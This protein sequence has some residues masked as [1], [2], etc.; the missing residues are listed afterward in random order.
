[1]NQHFIPRFLVEGFVAPEK[2]NRGVWVYRASTHGW[3]KRPTRQ[4]AAL[5]D[6][7]TFVEANGD[8]DEALEAYMAEIEREAAPYVRKIIAERPR[9]SKPDPHDVVVTFCALLICRNPSMIQRTKS[10]LE[11]YAQEML[12]EFT[13]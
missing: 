7:Y 6:F 12:A 2:G 5:E 10:V 3:S 13:A 1:M 8:R 9:L 4:T 11:Q